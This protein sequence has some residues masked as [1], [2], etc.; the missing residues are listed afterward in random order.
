MARL[1]IFLWCA[2]WL[3]GVA[4]ADPAEQAWT[5]AGADT[6]TTA[7]GLASGLVEVN[8]LGPVGAL[9]LKAALMGYIQGQPE[10]ARPQMYNFV[11]SLWGGAAA[12]NLCWLAGVGPVCMLIGAVTGQW[13]WRASEQ[14]RQ[15]TLAAQSRPEPHRAESSPGADGPGSVLQWAGPQAAAMTEPARD[16]PHA[17]PD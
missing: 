14:E 17:S 16:L 9:A 3:H 1:W 10:E 13:I 4:R 8:P 11:S 12:N 7:V 2:L 6:A 15:A 5:A